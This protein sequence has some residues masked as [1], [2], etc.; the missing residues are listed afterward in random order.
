MDGVC[1]FVCSIQCTQLL[2]IL[3]TALQ[4]PRL[5]RYVLACAPKCVVTCSQQVLFI[6]YPA[7]NSTCNSR[8]SAL[9]RYIVQVSCE[10]LLSLSRFSGCIKDTCATFSIALSRELFVLLYSLTT[11]CLNICYSYLSFSLFLTTCAKNFSSH[12]QS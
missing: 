12:V 2:R 3:Q 1:V 11:V 6:S 7:F 10:L 5:Q 4:S 9:W 8:N